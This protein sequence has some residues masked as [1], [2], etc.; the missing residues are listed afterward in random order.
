MSIETVFNFL[1]NDPKCFD[2]AFLLS[3]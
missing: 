3:S 2:F 1:S